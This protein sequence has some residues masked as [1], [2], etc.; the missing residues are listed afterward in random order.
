MTGSGLLV[1]PVP[2]EMSW[3]S[4]CVALQEAQQSDPGNEHP[5][6]DE[7]DGQLAP[8]CG[9][10]CGGARNA[11]ELGDL[12]DRPGQPVIAHQL[13]PGRRLRRPCVVVLHPEAPSSHLTRQGGDGST[14]PS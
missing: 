8:V 2:V 7:P 3:L 10:I 4:R 14:G 12:S 5:S 1:A 9:F 13:G 11:E 6:A